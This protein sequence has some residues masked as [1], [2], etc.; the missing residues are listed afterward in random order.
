MN[1]NPAAV[2]LGSIKSKKKAKSSAENGKKG[3]RPE[4]VVRLSKEE[5]RLIYHVLDE[6]MPSVQKQ[7]DKI[8]KIWNK[9]GEALGKESYLR[10]LLRESLK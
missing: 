5:A 9:L 6:G 4:I 10:K 1:K 3:G 8:A 2:S 7:R